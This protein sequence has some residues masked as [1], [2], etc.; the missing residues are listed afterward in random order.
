[1]SKVEINESQVEAFENAGFTILKKFYV[2]PKEI[3]IKKTSKIHV[4]KEAWIGINPKGTEPVRGKSAV[5]WSKVFKILWSKDAGAVY[6]RKTI[7][8]EIEA[9]QGYS[10]L[11][12]VWM[13]QNKILIEVPGNKVRTK[14]GN[15]KV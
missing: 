7:D 13:N 3:K 15:L 11:F 9:A 6:Q 8:K 12:P 1:M 4:S 5:V 2:V 14:A 10:S